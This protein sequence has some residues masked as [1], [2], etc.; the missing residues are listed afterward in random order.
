MTEE[1]TEL[2]TSLKLASRFGIRPVAVVLPGNTEEVQA[3]VKSCNRYGIGYKAH[4]TGWGPW[5]SPGAMGIVQIDMRRMNRIV[6]I[7]EED[8]YAVIEP[9]VVW[10]TLQAETM[11]R[12]LNCVTIGAG[13][14]CSALASI[15]SFNGIGYNNYS[16]GMNERTCWRSSGCFP[17]ARYSGWAR[18]AQGPDGSPVTGQGRHCAG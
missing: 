15:T 11:K 12:G 17:T 3:V 6:E 9:Y 1:E 16:M 7:N 4:S 18:S 2:A 5:A 10:A 8:M 14:N 13:G